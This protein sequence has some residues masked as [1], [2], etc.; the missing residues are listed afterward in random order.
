VNKTNSDIQPEKSFS[1]FGQLD[2][3]ARRGRRIAFLSLEVVFVFVKTFKDASYS[4]TGSADQ[5]GGRDSAGGPR[6][7]MPIAQAWIDMSLS[8]PR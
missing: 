2:H 3:I 4:P 1:V 8:P 7:A 5:V 6:T